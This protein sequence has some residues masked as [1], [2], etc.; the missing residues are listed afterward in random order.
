MLPF[1]A[2]L[3]LTSLGSPFSW[4]YVFVIGLLFILQIRIPKNIR[5]I[6]IVAL[7][8]GIIMM[9][10]SLFVSYQD[11]PDSKPVATGGFPITAFEYPPGAL[12]SNV[13]PIDSWELFYLNL[14]FWIVIG[15]GL[16]ILL[17]KYLNKK[18]CCIFL[19]ASIIIS[20]Y[21][22]GYILLKFD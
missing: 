13:P 15:T 22:L 12:G 17:R 4:L 11:L 16:T 3:S 19:I 2:L 10:I 6:T 14:C 9:W 8:L 18:R 20:I 5:K 21:G 7:L 1:L